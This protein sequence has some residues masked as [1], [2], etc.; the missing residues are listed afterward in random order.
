MAGITNQTQNTELLT[1]PASEV[2]L[3][4][5]TSSDSVCQLA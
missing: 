3:A 4:L 2:S 5:Q 1:K